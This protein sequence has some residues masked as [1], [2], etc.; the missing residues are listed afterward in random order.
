MGAATILGGEKRDD[1]PKDGVRE[2]ADVVHP[3]FYEF[4]GSGGGGVAASPRAAGCV[5]YNR[6]RRWREPHLLGA[7]VSRLHFLRGR[8]VAL[9]DLSRVTNDEPSCSASEEEGELGV[10]CRI[11]EE[12]ELGFSVGVR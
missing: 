1:L 5:I 7:G 2:I 12:V 10:F 4:L 8:R 11:E 6:R 3:R 9:T